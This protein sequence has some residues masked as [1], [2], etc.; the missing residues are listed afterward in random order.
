MK[1]YGRTIIVIAVLVALGLGYYYYL[2]NKDTGKDATDIA[3]DTSEVSV[4]IS[5][6]IMANYPESP[7]DVVNLYARITKAY[8]DTSLT[9]EQIEALGKQARLMFDD[10]L[11]NTQTDADFYEKLKEDIG[12][13]NSTKTRISSYVIQSAAKTKYSTFKDRQ[14][15]SIALVYYLRQG[16]KLIDSPTKFTLRKD[17]DGHWKILFWELTEIDSDT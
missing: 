8:Y 3:A 5:K 7:K 1:K 9:N 15:A 13:Y 16:D 2:A 10:E 12:N 11:K 14:Y 4:L 17:D 6:D